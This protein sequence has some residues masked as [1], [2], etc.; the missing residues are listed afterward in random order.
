MTG[1]LRRS[2]EELHRS[3]RQDLPSLCNVLVQINDT[4]VWVSQQ[5]GR[6]QLR[7]RSLSNTVNAFIAV[8]KAPGETGLDLKYTKTSASLLA[9]FDEVPLRRLLS[10]GEI[11]LVQAEPRHSSDGELFLNVQAILLLR[12]FQTFGR[13]QVDYESRCARKSYLSVTKG[14]GTKPPDTLHMGSVGGMVAHEVFSRLAQQENRR[15]DTPEEIFAHALGSETVGSLVFLGLKSPEDM[16]AAL[17]PGLD[18]QE[19]ITRSEALRRFLASDQWAPESD[20][21]NNG[22]VV[23]PDLLGRKHVAELKYIRPG[24]DYDDADKQRGQIEAYLAWAMVEYGLPEVCSEWKG[25][26]V[27]LHPQVDEA[28]R[29]RTLQAQPELIGGRLLKRHRLLA[30]TN[31]A[32][33]PAP[34]PDECN[35]CEF[36]D[37]ALRG[38][39]QQAAPA[40]TF[41]CQMERGWE[42]YTPPPGRACPLIDK[43]DQYN[44]FVAFERLDQF[45]RLRADLLDEEEERA[46]ISQIIEALTG[47][48]GGEATG[49]VLGGLKVLEHKP[50]TLKVELPPRLQVLDFAHRD[51]VFELLCEGRAA[52][53]VRMH[54][55]RG[56]DQMTL[57]EI[58]S[59]MR[60]LATGTLVALRAVPEWRVSPRDQLRYLDLVQRHDEPPM[61]L[62][63]GARRDRLPACT[64][65][66]SIE[67]LSPEAQLVLIDA[68]GRSALRTAAQKVLDWMRSSGTGRILVVDAIEG[69]QPAQEFADL[70]DL[71]LSEAFHADTLP[72]A[73]RL[74]ALVDGI[75]GKRVWCVPREQ[76]TGIRLSTL[77]ESLGRFSDVIIIGA[78]TFP[79]LAIHRCLALG[80]RVTLV[81]QA[82]ASGPR[83]ESLQARQSELYQNTLRLLLE[84]GPSIFPAQVE[85]V[86]IVRL[87]A[88]HGCAGS[89]RIFKFK[90][91]QRV[92]RLEPHPCA[93]PEEGPE[94]ST[95]AR[96]QGEIELTRFVP[97]SLHQVQKR[98]VIVEVLPSERNSV[99][100]LKELLK[101][102]TAR[103]IE[104]MNIMAKGH[105]DTALLG[106]RVRIVD[107]QQSTVS[108]SPGTEHR[109]TLR[110]PHDR[111]PFIQERLFT[112]RTEVEELLAFAK[113]RPQEQ[114][115]VTSPFFAQCLLISQLAMEKEIP[116]VIVVPLEHLGWK[117]PGGDRNLLVS[118]VVTRSNPG[119]PYPM[120]DLGRL[121][122]LFTGDY[123]EVHLFSSK[124]ALTHH[125]VL[126]RLTSPRL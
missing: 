49:L 121:I 4:P 76:L 106:E 46:A 107:I 6:W 5:G 54:K 96:V 7:V 102:I 15:A 101:G 86:E 118:T 119:Y 66:A 89:D 1:T 28:Q 35:Q 113:Q 74:R 91:I 75:Q 24:S 71:S 47:R 2:L 22:I 3:S 30:L 16:K 104:R 94:A 59:S 42:C 27:Q 43:C 83:A 111:F 124:E 8:H 25:L 78:E 34:N 97:L 38:E 52:G 67:Q 44:R 120:N 70:S 51:E 93:A 12:P 81:G 39:E 72:V 18:V 88:V 109:V 73:E 13:I 110:V 123:A 31:G 64:E 56:R 37:K 68:P 26:L 85:Q 100:H 45:N 19:V 29:V 84:A 92:S 62:R 117:R 50:S 82:S 116:N 20:V 108:A 79:L 21:L 57:S 112:S 87:P 33:L 41:H 90:G 126:L 53:L 9:M 40:C 115:H 65:L 14:V 105:L 99:R 103:S 32:W 61:S 63:S 48:E 60:P 95:Q 122:E 80:K 125:P 11:A 69:L 23:A 17:R 55:R 36:S 114:F 58:H 10:P 98:H 77:V